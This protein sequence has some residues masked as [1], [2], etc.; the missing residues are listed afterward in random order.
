MITEFSN[1]RK[2][3]AL[4][5]GQELASHQLERFGGAHDSTQGVLDL[6]GELIRE[7]AAALNQLLGLCYY[8]LRLSELLTQ[9]VH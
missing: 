4:V 8:L 3:A 7:A 6:M 1:E 2:A 5:G 9:G